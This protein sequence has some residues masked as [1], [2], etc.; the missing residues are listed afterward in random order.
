M[1]ACCLTYTFG[2]S[3]KA[4]ELPYEPVLT[5]L[6]T[7]NTAKEF[8]SLC[9]MLSIK[10]MVSLSVYALL[11]SYQQHGEHKGMGVNDM[12]YRAT[13]FIIFLLQ[14]YDSSGCTG[15]AA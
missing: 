12:A 11:L 4:H 1:R 10:Q 8:C 5:R 7:W 3:S 6:Q 2:L 15:S 9:G 14:V 13:D